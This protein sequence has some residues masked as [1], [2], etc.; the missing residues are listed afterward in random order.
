MKPEEALARARAAAAEARAQGAYG[1][2][3]SGFEV[4]VP[5]R[6]SSEQLMEWAV[7]EPDLAL[8]TS[9]R[10]WGAPIGAFKRGLVHLLRQYLKQ[11]ESQQ[12]RFN[13][14]LLVRV[15]ELEDRV[16]ELELWAGRD[17]GAPTAA[18][19]SDAPEGG[20]PS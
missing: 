17:E 8:V 16:S 14:H 2:D 11:L 4:R 20:A 6:R 10:S 15:A 9:T 12:T 19:E 3:L 1:D 7:I 18:H 5:E 13:V